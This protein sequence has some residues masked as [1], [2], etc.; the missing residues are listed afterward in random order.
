MIGIVTNNNDPDSLGRVKV[1][2][3]ALDDNLESEWMRIATPSAGNARGLMMLPQ[4]NEEVIVGFENGDTRR[5]YVLGSLF[6]G[7]DKPGGAHLQGKEA[8]DGS[9]AVL[10][11]KQIVA[12][13]KDEMKLTSTKKMTVDVQ[14]E[15]EIK[16][17]KDRTEQVGG[18][19]RTT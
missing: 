17:A 10:S 4:P 19:S 15:Q 7:K 11:D 13:S 6:N 5:G 12:T 8:R 16:V 18:N 1:K 14:D 3:P 2:F 9:F